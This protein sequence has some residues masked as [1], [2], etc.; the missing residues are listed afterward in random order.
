MPAERH[1]SS[2]SI[3]T[4][5]FVWHW[6]HGRCQIGDTSRGCHFLCWPRHLG[7]CKSVCLYCSRRKCL[8]QPA[9]QH[10]SEGK[11]CKFLSAIYSLHVVVTREAHVSSNW[12]VT[13]GHGPLECG[14]IPLCN[15]LCIRLGRPGNP[16]LC[17][18]L[19]ALDSRTCW[20]AA[21]GSIPSALSGFLH[22][23]S[24]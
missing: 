24:E 15:P 1:W 17:S 7:K 19:L 5:P 12:S 8:H 14:K 20:R 6:L 23:A 16:H 11:S 3:W 9:R 2:I 21:D 4:V 18:V 22:P 13:S 10:H